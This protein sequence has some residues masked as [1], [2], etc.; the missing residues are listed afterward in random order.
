MNRMT[1]KTMN[2]R[3]VIW[4][5]LVLASAACA[6]KPQDVEHLTGAGGPRS[7][8]TRDSFRAGL[9]EYLH[10][11]GDLCVDKPR[12]PIDVAAL[13]LQQGSRDARQLPVLA[14]L[15]VVAGHAV[16]VRSK[17]DPQ[18]A[19]RVVT[20]YELTAL[21]RQSF[22]D[23]H[24]RK[25]VDPNDPN[26]DGAQPDFCMARL[27]LAEIVGW[28][29]R[30]HEPNDKAPTGATV[31]YT[32]AV[33]APAWARDP[34]AERVFPA[35]GRVIEGARRATLTEDFTLTST[36]WVANELVSRSE[37]VAARAPAGERQP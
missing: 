1:K 22:I 12:W 20:R 14:R 32:Y 3:G 21:G 7:D 19:P 17:E 27:S 31:S 5:A 18:A 35:V 2:R 10:M 33:E 11:R 8:V 36:G 24:T 6:K 30:P 4:G 23:R 28:E 34:E 16:T 15:G 26:D 25:P 9:V 29:L 13:D 37:A